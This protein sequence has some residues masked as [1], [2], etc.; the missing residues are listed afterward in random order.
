MPLSNGK[1]GV[2]S[3]DETRSVLRPFADIFS[4]RGAGAAILWRECDGG[5]GWCVI[6]S[7]V[8]GQGQVT[9]G[10]LRDVEQ[11]GGLVRKVTSID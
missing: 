11:Q 1:H 8:R 9:R 10:K 7:W 5:S 3:G 4:R 6:G 2:A